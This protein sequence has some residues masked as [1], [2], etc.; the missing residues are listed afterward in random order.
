MSVATD[1]LLLVLSCTSFYIGLHYS[2]VV[3][4]LSKLI[5][6]ILKIF[7]KKLSSY[8]YIGFLWEE[9]S[10]GNGVFSSFVLYWDV[11][12]VRVCFVGANGCMC[13]VLGENGV[14][15]FFLPFRIMLNIVTCFDTSVRCLQVILTLTCR[16]S[17]Y[18]R[19]VIKVATLLRQ[20]RFICTAL[21]TVITIIPLGTYNTSSWY[22]FLF[23]LMT[24]VCLSLL[25]WTASFS[26]LLPF[27]TLPF[28]TLLPF[29]TVDLSLTA[30]L[31]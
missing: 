9:W 28:T 18:P 1:P 24:A 2:N 27:T 7:S 26:P 3:K 17:G 4:F 21:P 10:S 31:L 11:D 13:V 8:T 6:L 15:R 16:V 23:S 30:L 29:S 25:H 20:L 5:K 12:V 19:Q 22:I 14:F